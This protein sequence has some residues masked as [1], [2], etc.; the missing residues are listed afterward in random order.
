VKEGHRYKQSFMYRYRFGSSNSLFTKNLLVKYNP[1]QYGF[2]FANLPSEPN[3]A[4]LI[5]RALNGLNQL[6]SNSRPEGA[7]KDGPKDRT[8]RVR[9]DKA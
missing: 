3:P 9:G 1:F 5:I 4:G 2:G 6:Q 8:C 7:R